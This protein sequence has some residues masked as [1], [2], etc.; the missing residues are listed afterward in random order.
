MNSSFKNEENSEKLKFKN[1]KNKNDV[2]NI[3]ER[4]NRLVNKINTNEKIQSYSL[5]EAEFGWKQSEF[6]N[7]VTPSDYTITTVNQY[8]D[9]QRYEDTKKAPH[10]NMNSKEWL[11]IYGV[12]RMQLTLKDLLSK[13]TIN[14]YIFYH[15]Q[16]KKIIS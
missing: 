6:I 2:T 5:K 14:K 12:E 10:M 11:S 3:K 4:K 15:T 7:S 16:I 8:N 13:G 9:I 1:E